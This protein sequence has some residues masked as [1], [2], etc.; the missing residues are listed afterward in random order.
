MAMLS[1]CIP[2]KLQKK[3]KGKYWAWVLLSLGLISLIEAIIDYQYAKSIGVIPAEMMQAP[4]GA[5]IIGF[6]IESAIF[7]IAFWLLSF[8][9]LLP[10]ERVHN[11]NRQAALEQER[12]A[13]ELQYLK[14]QLNPHFLFNGINSI[15]HLI[16]K[17][18]EQ[19]KHTLLTF[20]GLLRHQLYECNEELIPLS[21]ELEYL[22]N[23]MSLEK[24]RKGSSATICWDIQVNDDGKKIAP[25][26]LQ[27]IIENAFKYLS[28]DEDPINNQLHV[29]IDVM[30]GVLDFTVTNTFDRQTAEADKPEGVGLKNFK[31]RLQLIYPH[32]HLLSVSQD[33]CT[34]NVRLTIDLKTS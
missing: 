24:I 20:S 9:Y 17:N 23:Y 25:M 31:R 1:G 16:D 21:Q 13:T 29:A 12:L 4:E 27:P 26:L 8:A 7:H 10:K 14:A 5:L 6:T 33:A 11:R 34:F 15:Y 22:T 28:H 32:Q 3:L 30:H 18:P 2:E 19:A